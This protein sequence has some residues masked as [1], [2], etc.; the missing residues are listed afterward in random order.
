VENDLPVI[1]ANAMDGDC[2]GLRAYIV[3]NFELAGGGVPS[4]VQ[5]TTA[6]N[7]ILAVVDIAGALD[8]AGVNGAAGFVGVLDGVGVNNATG[9]VLEI[10]AVL[11][12]RGYTVADGSVLQTGG[13]AGAQDTGAFAPQYTQSGGVLG[14]KTAPVI[15]RTKE[16]RPIRAT[17]TSGSLFA[18]LNEGQL[19]GWT[20]NA[21]TYHPGPVAGTVVAV[22]TDPVGARSPYP[23]R[24][25]SEQN[26]NNTIANNQAMRIATV[27]DDDGTVLG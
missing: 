8:I 6:A 12:G 24:G 3:D 20:D 15:A 23:F 17:F 19:A 26:V 2:S 9:T 13:G 21:Q 7:G 10:L 27:Y 4:A 5:A 14:N 11:S 16:T 25:G 22:G 18:S 1:T